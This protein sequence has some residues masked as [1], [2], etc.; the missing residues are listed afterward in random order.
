MI[1]QTPLLVKV[2]LH[3]LQVLSCPTKAPYLFPLFCYIEDMMVK[4][5]VAILDLKIKATC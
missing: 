4:I 5:G 1:C 2:I 3:C